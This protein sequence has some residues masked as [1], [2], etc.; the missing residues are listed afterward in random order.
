VPGYV[1]RRSVP[2]VLPPASPHPPAPIP[3]P[4][5]APSPLLQRS[6]S[7]CLYQP[8]S[9]KLESNV[10]KK[11]YVISIKLPRI[12][13]SLRRCTGWTLCDGL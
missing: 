6:R 11:S 10:R 1:L 7:S 13:L 8:P 4:W 5:L 3:L 12:S 2:P 9:I